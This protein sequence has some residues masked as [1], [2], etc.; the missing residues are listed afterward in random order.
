MTTKQELEQQLTFAKQKLTGE[1][2][3]ESWETTEGIETHIQDL[4]NQLANM[5]N[6][7]N[8]KEKLGETTEKLEKQAEEYYFSFE[9]WQRGSLVIALILLLILTVYWL[10]K[11]DKNKLAQREARKEAQLEEKWLKQMTLLK[12]LKE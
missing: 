9:P 8:L 11:E 6:T 5:T 10:A 2:P 3:L 12:R 4:E 1:V 7:D